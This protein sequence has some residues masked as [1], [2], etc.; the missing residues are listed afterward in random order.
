MSFSSV[1]LLVV[2]SVTSLVSAP[3]L[4]ASYSVCFGL[5]PERL[6]VGMANRWP[7]LH[8]S[9]SV[10]SAPF[11]WPQSLVHSLQLSS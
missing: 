6:P 8:R 5:L 10:S 4:S 1:Q 2:L 9:D 3:M 7:T 11:L